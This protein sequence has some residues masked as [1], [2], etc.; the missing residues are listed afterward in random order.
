MRCAAPE[1]SVVLPTFN[2]EA[3]LVEQ[4]TSILRQIGT[5]DEVIVVDDASTDGTTALIEQIDDPRVRLFVSPANLGVVRTVERGLSLIRGNIVL[6]SDQDDIWLA[7][8][9]DAIKSAFAADPDLVL[10]MSD[11]QVI[12]SEKRVIEESFMRSRG[13][14]RASLAATLVRNR[15]LGCAMAMRSTLLRCALPIPPDVP[16]H[17]MWFGA[18]ASTVGRVGYIDRP[19][20]Q[21][22]RHGSNVSPAKPQSL[23][24]VISWRWRL[25]RNVWQRIR[26]SPI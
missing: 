7:G 10:V 18:L 6:M 3:F 19:L 1:I 25:A 23:S 17:D 13:G 5:D 21:Y 26:A 24:K 12:D 15:F 22:R 4:L 2:G 9:V 11:A 16:M 14:F 8:K 20:I